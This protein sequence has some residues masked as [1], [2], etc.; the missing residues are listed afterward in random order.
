VD[1]TR[2]TMKSGKH[3]RGIARRDFVKSC[4][5]LMALGLQTRARSGEL[6]QN[7][8]Y[9]SARLVNRHQETFRVSNL[10]PG[11]AYLF[12]YPFVATPCFLINLGQPV[13]PGEALRTE[14]GR[15]Y[16]WPGGAGPNGSIV[17]F[18]AICA[19]KL[20]HPAKSVSF[21]NYR[22][23]TVT[24][25]DRNDEP[26]RGRHVIYCCSENS[27]Y[28]VRDGARVLGGPARQPLTAIGLAYDAAE[29]S[30]TATGTFGGELYAEYF[31]RFRNRLQLE[32][33]VTNIDDPVGASSV[34]QPLDEFTDSRVLC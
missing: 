2:V 11:E 24:Y 27:V 23:G 21:I 5:G 16:Q 34:V 20:T 31:A 29:D 26:A 19:H 1:S 32:Y 13:T 8:P 22:P 17:A 18:S 33:R 30:L 15:E 28:D 6:E 3:G 14:S 12:H 10:P 7:Q 25:T 9:A 4:V